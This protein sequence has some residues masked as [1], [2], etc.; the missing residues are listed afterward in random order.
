MK[1]NLVGTYLCLAAL[2]G[3]GV[4]CEN[5]DDPVEELEAEA[6]LDTKA[7]VGSELDAL[8][9]ATQ[10][11]QAAA[12]AADDDGWNSKDD[13][14]AVDKM[15]AAWNEA[16]DAY[17]HIEGSIAIVF[18]E[19][20][21]STDERYDGFIEGE[22]D[23]NL[24]DGD[25]VTGMHAIERILWAGEHPASV[26]AFEKELDGYKEAAFPKT[27]AEA[28]AFK[29]ELAQKLIDDVKQMRDEFK[30]LRLGTP[31]AFRGM[32][33]SMNE[34]LEKVTLATTAEDESRYAQ[35]TLD[36]MRANLE[37]AEKVYGAFRQWVLADA[38]EDVD[39]EIQAGF[40][41]IAKEYAANKGAAIPA[42]PDG[43]NPDEPSDAHLKTPYGKLYDL[44]T[45]ETDIEN[46]DSLISI[47]SRAA[48]DMGIPALGED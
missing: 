16:R 45:S 17:E 36:D 18:P 25:G 46:E 3:A 23:D 4:A 6:V 38:G 22:G 27:R 8:L 35:R 48:D 41:K 24:F 19:Q 34:Q 26:V 2:S 42:P 43:F 10:D 28:E 33:D 1:R 44:L 31:D 9:K 12:P 40:E 32:I 30:P 39:E 20:D 13:K 5:E 21:V 37:G 7:Y 47:M 15:R 11:I 29:T 14:A